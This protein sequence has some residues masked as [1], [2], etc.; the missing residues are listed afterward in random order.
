MIELQMFSCF[1]PGCVSFALTKGGLQTHSD[2]A[3]EKIVF[4]F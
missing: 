3:H 2:V 1:Y 4:L